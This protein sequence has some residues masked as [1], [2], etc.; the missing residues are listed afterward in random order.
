M[1]AAH[2]RFMW[3]ACEW[4]V[5][6]SST[7]IIY[8]GTRAGSSTKASGFEQYSGSPFRQSPA[9]RLHEVVQL[10]RLHQVVARVEAGG[11]SP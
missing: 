5:T 11:Q 6:I 9:D 4:T 3:A 10:D 1:A 7:R 2:L 8:A